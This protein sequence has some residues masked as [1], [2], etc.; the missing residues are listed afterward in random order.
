MYR[1]YRIVLVG[2]A[3][4]HADSTR[5]IHSFGTC[6][7]V[8]RYQY[9]RHKLHWKGMVHK[10]SLVDVKLVNGKKQLILVIAEMVSFV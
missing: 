1:E 2:I 9:L 6:V 4:A 3:N 7:L 10:R 8:R 5:Q